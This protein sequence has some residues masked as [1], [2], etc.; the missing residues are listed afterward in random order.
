M[1]LSKSD[2][3][4]IARKVHSHI[5]TGLHSSMWGR[6]IDVSKTSGVDA[7]TRLIMDTLTNAGVFN[8]D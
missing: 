5:A 2:K 8:E 7:A 4:I 6:A 3:A 1:Q